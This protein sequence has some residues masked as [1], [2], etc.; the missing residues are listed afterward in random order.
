MPRIVDTEIMEEHI[1]STYM[2][3]FAEFVDR[4]DT[5]RDGSFP[6][7]WHHGMEIHLILKG[8]ARFLVNGIAY[9]VKE[10]TGIYI[11]SRAIHSMK[12]A[13]NGTI[14]YNIVVDPQ[15]FIYFLRNIQCTKYIA[16]LIQEL[17]DALLIEN[18]NEEGNR[19]LSALAS[20]RDIDKDEEAYELFILEK[21]IC[22][23]RSLYLIVPHR[24][25]G[26][27]S[28]GKMLREKRMRIM[29][30]FIRKH[31]NEPISIRQIAEAANVSKSE[32]YRC[33]SLLSE[34]PPSEYLNKIRLLHAAQLLANTNHSIITICYQVGFN[35]TSYFAKMFK[36][37]YGL[38]PRSY[39]NKELMAHCL[40]LDPV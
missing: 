38:S 16:P 37:E 7:H 14:S 40:S 26:R 5:F 23:W 15:I 35:D 32:C 25:G 24:P 22:L 4:F 31:F 10:G 21:L 17:P 1:E 20:I 33:F 34:V 9:T 29:V 27:Q 39:R 19:V 6:S 8:R 30:E 2:V 28:R 18:S 13:D 12:K 11:A 3:P 36:R